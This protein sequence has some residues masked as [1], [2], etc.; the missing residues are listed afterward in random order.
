MGD[1]TVYSIGH[2]YRSRQQAWE[3]AKRLE[4]EKKIPMSVMRIEERG[5]AEYLV[6][7][8]LGCRE[9]TTYDHPIGENEHWA[10]ECA[11]ALGRITGQLHTAQLLRKRFLFADVWRVFETKVEPQKF[12]QPR[13]SKTPFAGIQC[14]GDL[15]KCCGPQGNSTCR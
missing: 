15:E 13:P 5:E 8:I 11:A 3:D 12:S 7:E 10:K 9:G 1:K 14:A 2:V 4:R 6:H